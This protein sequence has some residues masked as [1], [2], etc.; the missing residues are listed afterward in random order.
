MTLA[1]L[2]G[3]TIAPGE[4]PGPGPDV[5]SF[6]CYEEDNPNWT[7]SGPDN[8]WTLLADAGASGDQYYEASAWENV[9]AEFNFAASGFSLLYHKAPDGGNAEVY[10]DG[11]Y[12]DTLDMSG[13]SAWL[14]QAEFNVSGLN[15]NLLHVV[16]VVQA[17]GG[18]IYLDRLDLPAYD[19]AYNDA[20]SN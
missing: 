1:W 6:G 12:V 14:D 19:A 5:A 10:V 11:L 2:P 8:A 9:Y 15:P 7:L 4:P 20:C 17:G 3:A 13:S 16:R 18:F